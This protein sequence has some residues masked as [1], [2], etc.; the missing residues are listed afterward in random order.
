MFLISAGDAEYRAVQLRQEAE[1]LRVVSALQL[2]EPPA[3]SAHHRSHP[4]DAAVPVAGARLLA[5]LD[6][7]AVPEVDLHG[8]QSIASFG[9]PGVRE[10]TG[11]ERA[12][13]GRTIDAVLCFEGIPSDPVILAVFLGREGNTPTREEFSFLTAPSALVPGG[14]PCND[15]TRRG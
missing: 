13:D 9:E 7:L 2:D 11:I 12:D 15:A 6:V 3:V 5:R 10:P 8:V 1:R 4:H 14:K